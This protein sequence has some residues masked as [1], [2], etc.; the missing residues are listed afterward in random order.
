MEYRDYYQ[1][2][3]VSRDAP[4]DEIQKAYRKLA[5]KFHPDVNQAEEAE[6]RF[7]EIN[8]AYEVLKDPEKRAKYDQFGSAWKQAQASGSPPPGFEDVFSAFGFGGAGGRARPG[9]FRG[10]GSSG[11]SS[12]FETLFGSE[13]PTGTTWSWRGR[14][15]GFEQAPPAG[16]EE[17]SLALTL[18]EAARGGERPLTLRDAGGS[19]R[20]LTVRI[21]AGV[22][23]GQRIRLAGQAGERGSGARGDL[24]LRVRLLPTPLFRLEDGQLVTST[25][26][27]LGSGAWARA[28]VPT[29]AGPVRIRDPTSLVLGP[30]DQ[31]AAQGLPGRQG[32]GRRPDRRAAH[33]HPPRALR[34]RGAPLSRARRQLDVRAAGLT[35]A[36]RQDTMDLDHLTQKSQE[37]LQR[38]QDEATRRGHQQLD[39]E[40]LLLALLDD[41]G[42]LV[43]RLLQ[44]MDV[45]VGT[46]AAEVGKELAK[47]PQVSGPGA[48]ADKVYVTPRVNRLLVAAQDEAKRLKDEYVSVEHS[49][50]A[51]RRGERLRPPVASSPSTASRATPSWRP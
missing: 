37:A 13:G 3:G 5:R 14:P 20:K 43:P 23:E 17:A 4:Q 48:E 18:E 39:G 21:P 16:D 50:P 1:T 45:P 15:S 26:V 12:F 34:H 31:A 8:E 36:E 46:L 24:Y 10:T 7:K 22:Q 30:Q 35:S 51:S 19:Q 25:A 47:R 42:G 49:S 38:A 27:T 11:F 29:L 41:E 40:H 2:L 32:Q 28:D 6:S 44:R 9:G 33:R